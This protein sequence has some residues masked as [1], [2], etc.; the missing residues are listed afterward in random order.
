M[1]DDD[2]ERDRFSL[3]WELVDESKAID[4]PI[5][6]GIF[7]PNNDVMNA[8]YTEHDI[9][10]EN[11]LEFPRLKELVADHV[12]KNAVEKFTEDDDS[13]DGLKILAT[14]YFGSWDVHEINGILATPEMREALLDW[15]E[16]ELTW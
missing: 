3:F 10:H 5:F 6:V 16:E 12:Y 15:I 11:M 14:H 2:S 13:I 4:V 8:F 1:D 7:M 9:Y